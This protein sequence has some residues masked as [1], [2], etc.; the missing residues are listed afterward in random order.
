MSKKNP[1]SHWLS[2]R[3]LMDECDFVAPREFIEANGYTR[4]A[5]YKGEP[6]LPRILSKGVFIVN[7]RSFS[8][9]ELVDK[10]PFFSNAVIY[11]NPKTDECC[12]V[13]SPYYEVCEIQDE[14]THWSMQSGLDVWFFEDS[15]YHDGRCT[16]V[17]ALPGVSINFLS[18]SVPR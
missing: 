6:G 18:I 14:V 15:W 13:Y 9:L 2:R 1:R 7:S 11:K 10:A 4:M 17:M 16:I 3:G 12:L 8:A 5:L